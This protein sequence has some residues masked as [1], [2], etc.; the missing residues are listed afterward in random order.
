[1]SEGSPTKNSKLAVAAAAV[2]AVVAG[3]AFLIALLQ[4]ES[5][6]YFFKTVSLERQLAKAGP[7]GEF[8]Y[9]VSLP[10]GYRDDPRV[11]AQ[12][13]VLEDG[14]PLPLRIEKIKHVGEL[15]R[16]RYRVTQRTIYLSP[17]D[18]SDPR[19]NGRSYELR[20]PRSVRPAAIWLPLA[21]LAGAMFYLQ[22]AGVPPLP[23]WRPRAWVEPALVLG[24]AFGVMLWALG[25]HA[26]HSDGW[27]IMRGV[28]FSDGIGWVELAKSLSEGRGFSGGFESHR[29]GYPILLGSFFSLGGGGSVFAAKLFNALV[30]S[31]GATAVYFLTR[32]AFGRGLAILMLV[33]LLLGTKF[34]LAGQMALTEPT[35]F[36]LA[37]VGLHQLYRACQ[38]PAVWR[39]AMAGIFL[40]LSNLVRPFTL[41]ALPLFGAL[42][43]WLAWRGRWGW[44][45]FAMVGVA[46]VGGA[47][48]IFGPWVV[49]QKL[50]WGVAT[51]DLNGAVM[52]YGAAAPPGEGEKQMLSARH[53]IEGD[54]AGFARSDHGA[55]YHYY[56]GRYRE[57]IG[58]DRPRYASAVMSNFLEYFS[59]PGFDDGE[60][61]ERLGA[62][63]FFSLVWLAWRRKFP[64][65]VLL[66]GLW[67]WIGDGIAAAPPVL[68]VGLGA[69]LGLVLH[70]KAAR[71]A[72]VILLLTLLGAGVLNALV[73]NFALNRG[74]VFV[75]WIAI[76][77]VASGITGLAR[78]AV[79]LWR[80]ESGQ[81]QFATR[82]AD[83][84]PLALV[85]I[86]VV[87][88]CVLVA[89]ALFASHLEIDSWE[90]PPEVAAA[91]R[92]AVA[93]RHPGIESPEDL[94]VA[95]VR[96]GEYRWFIRG[97]EDLG[98]WAR[99]FEV[100]PFDRTVA[101]ALTG[102]S[103]RSLEARSVTINLPGD[104]RGIDGQQDFVVVGLRN[105]DESA[106]LDHATLIV[107]ALALFPYDPEQGEIRSGAAHFFPLVSGGSHA[108]H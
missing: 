32:A 40:G 77:L 66:A 3:A 91:T 41:L 81:E 39:F 85:A 62:V 69:V 44:R 73:G 50:A 108:S 79:G 92:A 61:R 38:H 24:G 56:M 99:T 26:D 4:Q 7:S 95:R 105:I 9:R 46:Y 82:F 86:F 16:G 35:G 76:L 58:E 72:I 2:I 27:L 70:G 101:M 83:G 100:R 96:L 21:L 49:R 90:L 31:F 53:Y 43:L 51:L 18:N 106:T 80:G 15:G 93:E 23:P 75:E 94:Y 42:I 71:A 28:P 47:M 60:V 30:L 103:K 67:P 33:G 84:Y 5:G 12:A 88:F 68:V 89:K 87:G 74:T 104:Q 37:A 36:A 11:A 65:L 6:R 45:R 14:E 52:L 20:A 102:Y 48:L 19:S 57:V 17:P 55:R 29:G 1:M 63:F 25:H 10:K 98:N 22:R 64:P 13:I 97:G 59:A 107:E 34:Q 8:G 54:E 78:L